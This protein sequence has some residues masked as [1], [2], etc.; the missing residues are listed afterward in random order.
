MSESCVG[1]YGDVIFNFKKVRDVVREWGLWMER[2]ED[3]LKGEGNLRCG[4]LY[5]FKLDF[6]GKTIVMASESSIH[7]DLMFDSLVEPGFDLY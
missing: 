7:L 5:V 4:A 6:E 3:G 2:V 1:V